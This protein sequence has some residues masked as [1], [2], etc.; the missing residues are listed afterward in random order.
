MDSRW[1]RERF[2]GIYPIDLIPKELP[3][4]SVIIVNQDTSNQ[5]GS[6]W[7]VI[8]YM[9]DAIVEYFDSVGKQ[10]K[11]EVHNLLLSQDMTYMYNNKRLQSYNTYTSWLFC[12]YYSYYS[13]RGVDFSSIL[14]RFSDN[15]VDNEVL[16]SRFFVDRFHK[17]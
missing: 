4:R 16:V 9:S 7:V 6:H 14:S 15:L 13:C 5:K 10:P 12:L 2:R 8:H 17:R 3:N 1:I 11:V